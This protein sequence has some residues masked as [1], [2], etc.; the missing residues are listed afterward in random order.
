VGAGSPRPLHFPAWVRSASSG[1]P[2]SRRSRPH[3]RPSFRVAPKPQSLGRA[4]DGAPGFPGCNHPSALLGLIHQVSLSPLASK[5]A[6]DASRATPFHVFWLNRQSKLRVS[7]PLRFFGNPCFASSSVPGAAWPVSPT[8]CP[9]ASS[10][11]ASSGSSRRSSCESPRLS[12]PLASPAAQLRVSPKLELH[13]LRLRR[14][15]GHPRVLHLPAVP[16]GKA[17]VAPH[18]RVH[19]RCRLVDLRV[20]L[21]FAPSGRSVSASPGCPVSAATAGSMMSPRLR[22]NFASSG[23]PASHSPGVP[24]SCARWL[25]RG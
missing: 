4:S 6:D 15:P 24:A 1:S 20:P 22:S 7:P 25:C 9:R 19:R 13:Q 3:R 11:T 12:S 2:R 14:L 18:L 21:D 5:C 23:Y 10:G 8:M 17:R 16:M